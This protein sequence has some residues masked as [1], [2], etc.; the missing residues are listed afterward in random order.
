[1][2]NFAYQGLIGNAKPSLTTKLNGQFNNT[3]LMSE[4]MTVSAK[5]V[6]F[7]VKNTTV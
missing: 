6:L 7:S 4:K 2:L 5:R 1:M 3:P